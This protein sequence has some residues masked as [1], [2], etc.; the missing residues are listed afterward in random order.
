MEDSKAEEMFKEIAPKLR[1]I[2]KQ[3]AREGEPGGVIYRTAY[4]ELIWK[5]KE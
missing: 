5:P 2:S 1:A 4:G 3:L